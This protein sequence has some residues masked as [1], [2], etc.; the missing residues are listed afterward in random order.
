[1]APQRCSVWPQA[2]ACG[3][4]NEGG[5]PARGSLPG[6]LA[7]TLIRTLS[8]FREQLILLH[9]ENNFTISNTISPVILSPLTRGK[10]CGEGAPCVSEGLIPAHA[11]KTCVARCARGG[12]RAHPRSRGKN[13]YVVTPWCYAEGSSPLSWGKPRIQSTISF[14]IRIIPTHA[15]KTVRCVIPTRS[16]TVHPR[17]RGENAP[18]I[19]SAS[20]FQGSSPLTR[21]KPARTGGG[22]RARRLIPAHAG[23]TGGSRSSRLPPRAHPRSP[24]ENLRLPKVPTHFSGSSPL[25]RGKHQEPDN[26]AC[27]TGLIPA[28]AG[29]TADR[30]RAM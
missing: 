16:A 5:S 1:M 18:G 21:G 2:H 12:R 14:D 15:G 8:L 28:H 9:T 17:S 22:L 6:G 23:K 10:P 30:C 13:T 29:K 3:E 25:T 4:N 11:G 24:G 27:N 19:A 7:A 26:G 20:W